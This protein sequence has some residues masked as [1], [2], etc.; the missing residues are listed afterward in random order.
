[1]LLLLLCRVAAV[2]TLLVILRFTV[3][4][5]DRTH[6]IHRCGV[7]QVDTSSNKLWQAVQTGT[8]CGKLLQAVT[9]CDKLWQ[10]GT[11]WYKLLQSVTNCYKLLQAGR[12]CHKL[13]QAVSS[14]YKL[15]QVCFKLLPDVTSFH[16][17]LQAVTRYYKLWQAV[18]SCYKLWQAVTSCFKLIQAVA[19]WYRTVP[20]LFH[21]FF[22]GCEWEY[23]KMCIF[24]LIIVVGDNYV[25]RKCSFYEKSFFLYFCISLLLIICLDNGFLK[26]IFC[27]F[28]TLLLIIFQ[29][30][31]IM[32]KVIFL[33]FWTTVNAYYIIFQDNDWAGWGEKFSLPDALS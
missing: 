18:T 8:I 10:A 15:S 25:L 7:L 11:S 3:K 28:V 31:T 20:T 27:I 33:Y 29:D 24:K 1:M 22:I 32:K 23:L 5:E 6:I 17:L 19:V 14:C 21:I 30:N 13:L 9:S 4:Q 16:K 12:S 2:R 26:Q